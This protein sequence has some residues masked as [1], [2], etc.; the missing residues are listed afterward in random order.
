MNGAS[1]QLLPSEQHLHDYAEVRGLVEIKDY[2][3]ALAKL[4]DSCLNESTKNQ[5]R[6]ALESS[7]DYVIKRTFGELDARI[8]QALCWDCWRL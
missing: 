2:S 6:I 8:M 1:E 3:E 7:D 4:K 5:L